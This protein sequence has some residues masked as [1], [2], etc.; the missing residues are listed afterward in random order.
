M[1]E[2][3]EALRKKLHSAISQ[4]QTIEVTRQ[5]QVSI[6]AQFIAKLSLACKGIDLELDN[7]LATFRKQLQQGAHFQELGP[8]I[9]ELSTLLTRHEANL[10]AQ[11]RQLQSCVEQAGSKLQ[12]RKGLP[13]DSRRTLRELLNTHL[14]DVHTPLDF[15]PLFSRLVNIYDQVLNASNT[16]EGRDHAGEIAHFANELTQLS[17]EVSVQGEF[18]EQMRTLKHNINAATEFE[19]LL[20]ASI[21]LTRIIVTSLSRERR[22]AQ[23]FLATLNE[24]LSELQQLLTNTVDKSRQL[25]SKISAVYQQIDEN[26][27]QLSQHTEFATDIAELKSTVE[28]RLASLTAQLVNKEQLEAEHR[29]A[30]H[31]GLQSMQSRV[32]DLEQQVQHYEASLERQRLM[33]MQDGLTKLP[34]RIAFDERFDLELKHCHRNGTPLC[35]VVID[36]DHFKSINDT[37]GHSAGD[38]TLL[39]LASAMKKAIRSSDFIARYGGEEFVLVMPNVDLDNVVR[40]LEKLRASVKSIPF[41]FKDKQVQITVSIGATQVKANDT[42]LSAFDRADQALYEAKHAGRDR[43]VVQQ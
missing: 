1:S 15:I 20:S 27:N 26:I 39:V 25:D 29:D 5:E 9:A 2:Q 36:V 8:I 13:D 34:N 31:Q 7:R 16:T 4:R 6:L 37:Y 3:L 21:E 14:Q 30:L 41:K 43:L 38:K 32:Q 22:S 35:L 18:I 23:H 40:P 12:Q 28:L 42:A 10:E 24:S 17:T 33:N 19:Q 11:L